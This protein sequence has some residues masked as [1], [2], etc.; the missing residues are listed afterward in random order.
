MDPSVTMSEKDRKK[1]L[2]AA[3]SLRKTTERKQRAAAKAKVVLA[4]RKRAVVQCETEMP[5]VPWRVAAPQPPLVGGAAITPQ[6]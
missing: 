5:I 2:K 1:A 4:E 6:L 3:A